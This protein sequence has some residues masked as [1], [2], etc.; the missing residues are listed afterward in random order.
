MDKTT[1]SDLPAALVKEVLE[2]SGD[3]GSVLLGEFESLH[4]NTQQRRQQ[5]I[6]NDLVRHESNLNI[7]APTCCG[8]DGSYGIERLLSYDL[9]AAAAVAIEG[10]TPPSETRYWAEPYHLVHV[11]IEPHSAKS[12]NVLR[13]IMMGMELQL[14]AQAPHD[15]VMLDGSLTTPLIF[16]NQ[17]LGK[18]S[19]DEEDT[20]DLGISEMF[21]ENLKNYLESYFT[22]LD[23]RRTDKCYVAVPKYTTRREIGSILGWPEAYDDRAMLSNLLE[24]GQY[25]VPQQIQ[26]PGQPWHLG[27]SMFSPQEQSELK[28][29]IDQITKKLLDIHIVYYRPNQSLPAMRLEMSRSI[30]NTA[31]RLANA[32]YGTKHQCS[33]AAI[34]EPYPLYM[35]DRMVKSLASSV[36]TFRQIITQH[37][38]EHYQGN[39]SDVFLNLHGYRTEAGK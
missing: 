28:S 29:I 33:S 36:P 3:I 24:P 13:A 21:Q 26:K 6:D 27:I 14:A 25:T 1:F 35:A 32:I 38:S 12:N 20:V 22:I 8:V 19:S 30:A 18:I 9:V 11:A 4:E 23:S 2:L 15:V 34:Q 17:A 5:L 37:V 31:G 7:V 10:L 39:V 16:F